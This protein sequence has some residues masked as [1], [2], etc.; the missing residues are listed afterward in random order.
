LLAAGI[1]RNVRAG[2]CFQIRP[3]ARQRRWEE[4][5]FKRR[6]TPEHPKT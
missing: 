3:A 4:F 6:E 1:G 5:W 2:G